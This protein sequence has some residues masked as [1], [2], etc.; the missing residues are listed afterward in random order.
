MRARKNGKVLSL[1]LFNAHIFGSMLGV[2]T[3]LHAIAYV[4]ATEMVIIIKIVAWEIRNSI[5]II[6]INFL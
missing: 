6:P 4:A 5:I 1:W 2:T 3:T